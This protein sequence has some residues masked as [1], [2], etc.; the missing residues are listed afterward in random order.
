[1]QWSWKRECSLDLEFASDCA[2]TFILL[3]IVTASLSCG[4]VFDLH[5]KALLLPGASASNLAHSLQN[6]A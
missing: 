4:K 6:E 3:G 1:M 2:R 5:A